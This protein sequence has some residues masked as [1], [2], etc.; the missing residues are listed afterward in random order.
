MVPRMAECSACHQ[1]FPHRE[2]CPLVECEHGVT[3]DH[4]QV[5]AQHA[6]PKQMT[7]KEIRERWPRLDG[8]CPIGCGYD[9][10]YYYSMNHYTWGEWDDD[11][12]PFGPQVGDRDDD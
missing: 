6:T 4:A 9:G 7:G 5:L 12:I 11:E 3:Y 10:V 8:K 2:D 1:F